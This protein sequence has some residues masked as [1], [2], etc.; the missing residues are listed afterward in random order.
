[1]CIVT[2]SHNQL[3]GK[4]SQELSSLNSQLQ[5]FSFSPLR[6]CCPCWTSSVSLIFI[7]LSHVFR[8][9]LDSRLDLAT[10]KSCGTN[11]RCVLNSLHT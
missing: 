8:E 10:S 7:F 4:A 3:E 6:N 1:M 5:G 11:L 2:R 9:I